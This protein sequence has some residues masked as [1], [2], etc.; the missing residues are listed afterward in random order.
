MVHGFLALWDNGRPD[1]AHGQLH[2]RT[3]VVLVA[4]ETRHDAGQ[5][6]GQLLLCMGRDAREP[7]CSTL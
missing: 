1:V 5:V 3:G 2:P 7:I 4:I 6:R